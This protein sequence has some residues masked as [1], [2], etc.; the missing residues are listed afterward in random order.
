MLTSFCALLV[1][2]VAAEAAPNAVLKAAGPPAFL[3][4]DPSDNLCLAGDSFRRC[5]IETLWFVSGKA[6]NY[7]IHKRPVDEADI[8]LCLDK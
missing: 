2:L 4:S 7:Q 6:G 8:D 3:I 5:S 1:F